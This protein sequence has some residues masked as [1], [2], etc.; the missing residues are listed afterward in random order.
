MIAHRSRQCLIQL[1]GLH[2]EIFEDSEQFKTYAS[3]VIQQLMKL[4]DE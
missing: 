2:G 4:M 1:S 3:I